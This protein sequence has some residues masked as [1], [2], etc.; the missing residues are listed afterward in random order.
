MNDLP[1][2]L[3]PHDVSPAS[4][5]RIRRR[6]LSVLARSGAVDERTLFGRLEGAWI[7][8]VEPT[9]V[10]SFSLAY[11]VWAIAVVLGR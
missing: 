4:A 1:E 5:A 8:V 2:L 9:L 3:T 10:G 11:A 6:A 7:R